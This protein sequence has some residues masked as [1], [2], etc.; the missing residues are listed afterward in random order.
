M[1]LKGK[2][3]TFISNF[4]SDREF[5]VRVNSTY[6]APTLTESTLYIG[7]ES[8]GFKK[9]CKVS[10]DHPFHGLTYATS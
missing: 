4:L 1:G 2:L 5:N 10:I 8:N 9:P 6:R 3:P 7:Q